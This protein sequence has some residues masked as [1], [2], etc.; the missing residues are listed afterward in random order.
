MQLLFMSAIS[1][2]P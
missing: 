1:D 2:C